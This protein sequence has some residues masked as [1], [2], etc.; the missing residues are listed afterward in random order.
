MIK[1]LFKLPSRELTNSFAA[2]SFSNFKNISLIKFFK[3]ESSVTTI[4]KKTLKLKKLKYSFLQSH[5]LRLL[6]ELTE[7]IIVKTADLHMTTYLLVQ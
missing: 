2:S 5:Q 1:V 6:I 7:G 4:L 3:A